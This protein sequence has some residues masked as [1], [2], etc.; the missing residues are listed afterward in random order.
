V[1][2]EGCLKV[3]RITLLVVTAFFEKG[4]SMI[5]EFMIVVPV[6]S[7]SNTSS[8]LLFSLV[9]KTSD[10]CTFCSAKFQVTI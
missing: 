6:N 1:Q 7:Q 5:S 4:G 3:D 10:S 8:L 9:A 2:R